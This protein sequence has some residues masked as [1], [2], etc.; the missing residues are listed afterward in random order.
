ML[1][2][3]LIA[4]STLHFAGGRYAPEFRKAIKIK[5]QLISEQEEEMRSLEKALSDL[6]TGPSVER[7]GLKQNNA[8]EAAIM[9]DG[10]VE[11]KR[12]LKAIEG[13]QETLKEKEADVERL[14]EEID[15]M[16]EKLRAEVREVKQKLIQLEMQLHRVRSQ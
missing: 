15:A 11:L 2:C 13:E 9:K 1:E 10:Q 14:K 3:L 5:K 16:E 6:K 4:F 7:E 12:V 8:A